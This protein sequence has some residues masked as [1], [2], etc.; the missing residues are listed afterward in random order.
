MLGEDATAGE[1]VEGYLKAAREIWWADSRDDDVGRLPF[2]EL[3]GSL[4]VAR[5]IVS[6]ADFLGGRIDALTR[7]I[8]TL[9]GKGLA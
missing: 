3:V 2:Q 4:I 8:E 6:S 5:A 9:D 7:A 1:I